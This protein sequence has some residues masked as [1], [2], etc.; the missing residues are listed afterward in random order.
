M[1][2]RFALG[3]GLSAMLLLAACGGGDADTAAAPASAGAASAP[4]VAAAATLTCRT[5][6]YSVPVTLPTPAELS[7]FAGTYA[8]D[9]GHYGPNP[10]DPFVRSGAA[11]LV[12]QADG[13]VTYNGSAATVGSACVESGSNGK[14]LYLLFSDGA[15]LGGVDLFSGAQVTT[16]GFEMTG[17]APTSTLTSL[18]VVQNGHKR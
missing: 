11:T 3:L 10:G 4:G 16:L 18:V 17:T 6:A 13:T 12:L 2:Q 5:S 1:Q 8:G 7:A 9:E 15:G 14:T